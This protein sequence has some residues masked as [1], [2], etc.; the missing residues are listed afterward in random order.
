MK[1]A[2]FIDVDGTLYK[3][4]NLTLTKTVKEKLEEASKYV[5]LYIATGRAYN[6]LT[7]LNDV[8]H[9]FKGF[10][11]SNGSIVMIDNQIIFESVI[12]NELKDKLVA[13]S[14][15]L[16]A[17]LSLLTHEHIY[18]N[19]INEIIDKALT[20]RD[21]GSL[22]NLNSYDYLD[23]KYNMAWTFEN[24]EVIDVMEKRLPEFDFFKWGTRGADIIVKN[25]TKAKGIQMVLN[26][27]GY[28]IDKTYAIGDSSNDVP[29]FKLVNTPIA[30]GNA[31][32]HAKQNAKYVTLTQDEQGLEKALDNIIKGI[33]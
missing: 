16:N 4:H 11:V 17:S 3:A 13:C 25:I 18:T 9:L 28:D 5:D 8:K 14:K 20:P 2:V 6:V 29:M 27:M 15:S 10:V 22:I 24:T 1:K 26:K 12:E 19:T 31:T 30:M 7:C 33:W 32:E 23:I 21:E